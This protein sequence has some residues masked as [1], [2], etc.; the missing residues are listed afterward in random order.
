MSKKPGKKKTQVMNLPETEPDIQSEREQIYQKPFLARLYDKVNPGDYTMKQDFH[1]V[2]FLFSFIVIVLVLICVI[3]VGNT[4]NY[5][6]DREAQLTIPA[7]SFVKGQ[8]TNIYDLLDGYGFKDIQV[9]GNGSIVAYGTTEMVQAYKDSYKKKNVDK[10]LSSLDDDRT[11]QGIDSIMLSDD[12][13]TL[14]VRTYRDLSNST[15]DFSTFIKGG[16][17]AKIVSTL[18][19]W[20]GLRNDGEPLTTVFVNVFDMTS[21]TDGTEYYSSTRPNV[22]QMLADMEKEASEAEERS[23]EDVGSSETGSPSTD[24]GE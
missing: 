15:D 1:H 3:W 13:R 12:A 9:G 22:D 23:G 7:T 2:I 6:R 10:V 16:D 4:N 17:I 8:E 19:T 18:S 24:E 21:G 11:E 5:E 14:T 20:C